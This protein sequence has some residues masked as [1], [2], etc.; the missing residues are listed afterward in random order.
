M[1]KTNRRIWS[2]LLV[3]LMVMMTLTGYGE[4]QAATANY[5]TVRYD[6]KLHSIASRYQTKAK[7]N[8]K[9]VKMAVPGIIINGANMVPATVI[10]KT[11]ITYSYNK[12]KKQAVLTYGVKKIKITMGKKYAYVNG[13]KKSMGTRA[14]PVY[15][16]GAKKTCN[17][18]PARFVFEAMGM[19]YTWNNTASTCSIVT[20][21]AITAAPTATPVVSQEPTATVSLSPAPT[22]QVTDSPIPTATLTQTSES[23]AE[24]VVTATVIATPVPTVEATQEPVVVTSP[25]SITAR[26]ETGSALTPTISP[27][28]STGTALVTGDDTE[29]KA[30]WISYLEYGNGG[31]SKAQFTTKMTGIFDK[32]VEY[33]M[34]TVIVQVR[35]FSDAMYQSDYFPWSKYASGTAGKD[36]GYDPLEIMVELAHARGLKIHAWLNP[37]RVTLGSTKA[38][39]LPAGSPA[40]KWMQSS[41]ASVQRRV[42]TYGS[43]LYYNPSIS[44][45]RTLII[46][47]VKEIVEGYDVDGI[48]F[49]DYFYPNL[50]NSYETNFDAPE[51]QAYL[52]RCKEKNVSPKS[53]V[54][55]RRSNVNTLVK[56]VYAAVKEVNSKVEFGISPAGNISNLTSKNA[57]YVNVSTWMSKE[58]Y[59]DYI[60]PQIY[61]SFY[62]ATCPFAATVDKWASLKK[63]EK[64]KLYIGIAVYRAGSNLETEWKTSD[65]VLKRQIEYGRG[66]AAVNGFAFYR[67]DSFGLAITQK[68]VKNLV[69]V[70]K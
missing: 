15:Y 30:M 70:L 47:G 22:M 65:T 51:Y 2:V 64:I 43:N 69:A 68:E 14:L 28:V 44:A 36:P 35:P 52:E 59:V 34:N 5:M 56:G 31:Y 8:G 62:N 42:L 26:P 1:K 27:E 60:C 38:S 7:V 3:L 54:S 24:P 32:C 50:G 12:S 49:D 48:H 66:V 18:Y 20:V 19:K 23:T 10:K 37:Y 6:G 39:A 67:Y 17:L 16:V 13:K 41:D 29:M 25:V 63:N 21:P 58:G 33:G 61:W 46:N 53:I 4:G 9:K 45:V 57:Y 55:W 40:K 11:G